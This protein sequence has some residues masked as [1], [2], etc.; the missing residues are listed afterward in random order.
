MDY[1]ERE[2]NERLLGALT[3]HAQV[4]VRELSAVQWLL[5]A[6]LAVSIIALVRLW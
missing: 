3:G 6:Q 2:A 4:M 5:I 1:E